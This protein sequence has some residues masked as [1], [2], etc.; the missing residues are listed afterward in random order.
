M[1]LIRPDGHLV[2]AF[3]GV[4]PGALYA[5]ADIALGGAGEATETSDAG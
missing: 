4:Q 3:N 2:A 1:L 5:A